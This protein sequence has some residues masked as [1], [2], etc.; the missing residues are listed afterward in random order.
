MIDWYSYWVAS[1]CHTTAPY[2]EGENHTCVSSQG[3]MVETEVGLK[4]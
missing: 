2:P 4:I 1:S 3:E